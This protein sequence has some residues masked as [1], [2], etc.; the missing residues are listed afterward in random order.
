MKKKTYCFVSAL[1]LVMAVVLCGCGS[2]APKASAAAAEPEETEAPAL[3]CTISVSCATAL[4]HTDLL[5]KEK[6]ALV[7]EDGVIFAPAEVSFN[8]G[9]SAFAVLQRV[10]REN[11]IQMEYAE[12]PAYGGVYLKGINNLYEGDCGNL[13]YWM[14]SVNGEFL[15]FGCGDYVMQDGDVLCYLYTCDLGADIGY[16]YEAE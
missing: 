7:P 10:C 9:E 16:V 2:P 11:K 8:K 15:N 5:A 12:A 6:T 14:Y 4:D 3:H 1:A 13:S